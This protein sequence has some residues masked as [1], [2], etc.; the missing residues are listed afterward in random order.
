M[1]SITASELKRFVNCNG[2]KSLGGSPPFDPDTTLKDEGD[3]AHWL[4]QHAFQNDI[5]LE[6]LIDRKAGNGF[7]ITPDMVEHVEPYFR[8]LQILQ[9]DGWIV[10]LEKDT[11]YSDEGFEVKG[12][13]NT[14]AYNRQRQ[15]LQIHEFNYGWRIEELFENWSM[16]S[17]VMGAY[18]QLGFDKPVNSIELIIHQPRPIHPDGKIRYWKISVDEFNQYWEKMRQALTSPSNTCKT[19]EWCRKCPS[20]TQCPVGQELLN[21]A[22]DASGMAFNNHVDNN[23]LSIILDE[24]KRASEVLKQAEKAYNDLALHRIKDGGVIRN[25]THE[26]SYGRTKWKKDVSPETVKALTGIDVSKPALISPTQAKKAGLDEKMFEHLTEKPFSGF[27]IVRV[28]GSKKAE[29]L[30]RK[31]K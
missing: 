18:R 3:A 28:D 11:S 4:V 13:A 9:K 25:Y 26:S 5:P 2:S 6:E 23:R 1:L 19:G 31:D 10:E 12:R 7:Y 14:V 24:I 22:I 27:K 17:H 30:F 8:H 21:N 16:L 15:V 20:F 29:K